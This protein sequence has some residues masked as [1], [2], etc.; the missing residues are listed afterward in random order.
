MTE[1]QCMFVSSRGIL[2]SCDLHSEQ[3][4]SSCPYDIQHLDK[5]IDT[6]NQTPNMTIY[7]CPEA[8]THFVTVILEYIEV[9]FYLVSGDSDLAAPNEPLN[10]E[11]RT[12]LLENPNLLR[13]AGQNM[14]YTSHPKLMQIPIGLDYHTL[15]ANPSYS[16]WSNGT[17]DNSCPGQEA[18]LMKIRASA[19]PLTDRICK[20]YTNAHHRLDRYGDRSK[21]ITQIP[22]DLLIKEPTLILRTEVWRNYGKY[23]FVA[24]PFGNGIDCHRTWE[25]LCCGAI[26]IIRGQFLTDLFDDLPVLR[27]AAW[28]DVTA[29]LLEKTIKEFLQ[30]TFNY[31]KLTLKYWMDCIKAPAA[32]AAAS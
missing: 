18:T 32:P 16:E 30:R 17:E 6:N 8:L 26:P 29:E 21:A 14:M 4:I 28:S 23:A 15:A 1:S 19:L 31:N 2:K 24:S 27:V 11:L 10:D 25:A 7:V 5:L 13:W 22:S 3:P 20:V 12:R 9:P